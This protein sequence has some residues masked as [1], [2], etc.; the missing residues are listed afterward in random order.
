MQSRVSG[1][2]SM[3]MRYGAV[4]GL[5]EPDGH[6]S[7][8]MLKAAAPSDAQ[9][10]PVGQKLQLLLPGSSLNLPGL[11]ASHVV[12]PLAGLCVPIEHGKHRI[13]PLTGEYLPASQV[14]HE[15]AEPLSCAWPVAHGAHAAVP[16]SRV[17][18]IG[19]FTKESVKSRVV[20]TGPSTH[21]SLPSANASHDAQPP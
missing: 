18:P 1:T 15:V 14:T 10:P 9:K 17:W 4:L 5:Y 20:C 12:A 13:D 3:D 11:H 2:M 16:S 19:Q 21:R 6:A 8:V 7:N